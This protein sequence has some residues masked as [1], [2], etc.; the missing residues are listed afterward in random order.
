MNRGLVC[1]KSAKHHN[2]Q[3]LD[4]SVVKTIKDPTNCFIRLEIV[5]CQQILLGELT[6]GGYGISEQI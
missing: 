5:D 4:F 6:L 2:T 3:Y 1:L